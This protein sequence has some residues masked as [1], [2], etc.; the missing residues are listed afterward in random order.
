MKTVMATDVTLFVCGERYFYASQV[1]TILKRYYEYFGKLTICGRTIQTDEVPCSHEEVTDMIDGVLSVQSLGKILVGSYDKKIRRLIYNSDFV[2]CRCPGIIAQRVANIAKKVGKPYFAECM[3]CAWDAYWN[4]GLV[5]KAIAGYMFLNMRRAVYHANYA[6]Y[7]TSEFLQKRYP[8]KN[9]SVHASNVL[10]EC[11]DEAVLQKRQKRIEEAEYA[12]LTLMTTAAVDVRY[13]GQEYVIKAIP[14]LNRHGIRVRYILVGGGDASYLKCVARKHGVLEQ[15]EFAGRCS[16]SEVFGLLDQADIYLQPSLQEGLPRSV[17]EAM[18]RACPVIGA[19]TAG[20]PE[21]I[22][23]ECVVKRRS[24]KEIAKAIIEISND[25]KML[26]L[27]TRNF[28]KSKEFQD[29]VLRERRSKYYSN[30]ISA[31]SR[32]DDSYGCKD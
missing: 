14:E 8:C 7:V 1:S 3:G 23:P 10:I 9:E 19:K 13:K 11:A 17:V 25:E 6:L 32:G 31:M 12:Q 27:A 15:V 16:L 21:L 30:I 18:S 20:I 26:E 22:T 2:I 29:F 4:H 24:S 5:G 28:E